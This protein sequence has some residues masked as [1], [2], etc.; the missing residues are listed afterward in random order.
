MCV[1]WHVP[2]PC[3]CGVWCVWCVCGLVWAADRAGVHPI[4]VCRQG[5]GGRW[6]Q[7]MLTNPR[8]QWYTT[9]MNTTMLP[10]N[11]AS[12][13]AL[14]QD[15]LC[16]VWTGGKTEKGYGKVMV[17]GRRWRTHRYVWFLTRGTDP[18][19][20]VHHLCDNR[21]CCNPLHLALMPHVEHAIL[22]AR[23]RWTGLC[24]K[25]HDLTPENSYVRTKADGSFRDRQCRTCRAAVRAKAHAARHMPHERASVGP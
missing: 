12:R 8:I 2:S 23:A 11:V 16:W 7:R 14:D 25:G 21:A 19:D 3:V 17:A 10:K 13:I 22:S 5:V 24:G 6:D 20:D 4:A 1:V 18:A 15:T 9:C